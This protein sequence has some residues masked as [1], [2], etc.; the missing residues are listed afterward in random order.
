MKKLYAALAPL[1]LIPVFS[2]GYLG[3]LSSSCE[4]LSSAF[5]KVSVNAEN[6]NAEAQFF[7]AEKNWEKFEKIFAVSVNHTE[8][9]SVKQGISR[10]GSYL[11]SGDL[12]ELKCELNLVVKLIEHIKEL[13][14]PNL[15]NI[16]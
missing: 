4:K 11:E 1:L 16:F 15:R 8:L 3:Y 14:Y 2:L 9:D 13:E 5:E 7:E 10:A 12:T 6:E